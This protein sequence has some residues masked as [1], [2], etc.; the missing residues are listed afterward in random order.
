M[1]SRADHS[2]RADLATEALV[3]LEYR[4]FITFY[5]VIDNV[6]RI[7]LQLPE[8]ASQPSK[9]D[10]VDALQSRVRA[11]RDQSGEARFQGRAAT[12]EA[13]DLELTVITGSGP[14]ATL[15]STDG[16]ISTGTTSEI[17][18]T[19]T[20]ATGSGAEPAVVSTPNSPTEIVSETPEKILAQAARPVIRLHYARQTY[21]GVPG[22]FCWPVAPGVSLCGDEGPFPWR[23]LDL[24]TMPVT[25]GDSI[26]V[27]I[28]ADDRP[29]KLQARI[30]AE[31]S[32]RASDT[33]VQVVE[34]DPGLIAPLVVELPAGVYNMRITGQWGVGDQA[35]KFRMNVE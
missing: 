8:G 18:P 6:I 29:Q 25:A 33:A 32:E 27:E 9:S 13:Q 35:Y 21:D 34:L 28:E 16:V 5:D 24:S 14:I 3:D 23:D 20:S 15:E 7:K 31:A 19:Q 2:R 12:V 17:T 30:F 10:L 4:N 1:T 11:E 22:N 26:I